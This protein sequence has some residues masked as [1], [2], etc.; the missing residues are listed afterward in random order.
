MISIYIFGILLIAKS[1][2]ALI[3]LSIEFNEYSYFEN[4]CVFKSGTKEDIK[5][6]I[7][8]TNKDIEKIRI[9]RMIPGLV[10]GINIKGKIIWT[11][12]FGQTDI[13]NDFKTRTDSGEW[14]VNH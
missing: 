13:E 4:Q 6:S 3:S 5:S 14:R 8:K 7:Q 9:A 1:S 10:V 12:D 11:E 2:F